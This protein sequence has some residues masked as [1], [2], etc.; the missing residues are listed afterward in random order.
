MKYSSTYLK[1]PVNY[2]V[3]ISFIVPVIELMSFPNTSTSP[4]MKISKRNYLPKCGK[5]LLNNIK[6]TTS[7]HGTLFAYV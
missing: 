2:N 5:N 1:Y 6:K 4:T 7:A 3:T